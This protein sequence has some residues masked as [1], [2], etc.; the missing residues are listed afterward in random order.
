MVAG[1]RS[2]LK[3]VPRELLACHLGHH[4]AAEPQHGDGGHL[5]TWGSTYL[6]P[7]VKGHLLEARGARSLEDFLRLL[8]AGRILGGN[9]GLGSRPL[10]QL[11]LRLRGWGS[12]RWSQHPGS[13]KGPLAEAPGQDAGH[14]AAFPGETEE[15]QGPLS[16][17][18]GIRKMPP[19]Q[20]EPMS[21]HEKR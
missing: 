10:Q 16:G 15:T 20:P 19:T 21:V 18:W 6:L 7:G 4:W 11:C 17:I 14:A 9:K 13:Q 12:P 5:C 3:S 8:L 1:K 2:A